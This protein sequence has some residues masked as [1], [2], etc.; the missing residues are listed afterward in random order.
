MKRNKKLVSTKNVISAQIAFIVLAFIILFSA[1]S[2]SVTKSLPPNEK[3]YTGAKVKIEDKETPAKKKK[4]L[5]NELEGLVRPKPNT[6]ILGIP[7][8]LMFHNLIGEV[9]RK[10]GLGYFIKY[11]L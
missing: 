2:C 8:K 9:K 1:S 5:E 10:K 6:T 7:Y 3:L 11:K 4:T